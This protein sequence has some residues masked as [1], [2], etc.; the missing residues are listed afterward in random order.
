MLSPSHRSVGCKA[1]ARSQRYCPS[2]SSSVLNNQRHCMPVVP[3][4]AHTSRHPRGVKAGCSR[5]LRATVLTKN[6][7]KSI[8]GPEQLKIWRSAQAVCF[9]VDCAFFPCDVFSSIVTR[10]Y[11]G[12]P[13][14]NFSVCTGL[15]LVMIMVNFYFI[16]AWH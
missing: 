12:R 9:D 4:R 1:V 7:D 5:D 13:T 14:R 8:P 2:I 6:A 16:Q 10:T 11:R 3:A 15:P